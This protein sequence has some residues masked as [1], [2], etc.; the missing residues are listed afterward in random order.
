M[1]AKDLLRS[2]LNIGCWNMRTLVETEGSIAAS[3]SRPGSRGVV[4][5][6]KATLMVQEVIN[7][8]FRM[9]ITGISETK[10]FGQNVYNIDNLTILH[11]GHSIPLKARQLR[12]MKAWA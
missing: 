6:R 11:C 9:N 1:A 8:K 3:L 2:T 5:D 7:F 12:E 10:C 4:V